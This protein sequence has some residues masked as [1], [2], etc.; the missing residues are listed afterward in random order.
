M[1]DR[2]S[3]QRIATL[4]AQMQALAEDVA[5]QV[6]GHKGPVEWGD[7]DGWLLGDVEKVR[8]DG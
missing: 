5:E 8:D 1:A 3:E 7:E 4:E 6:Y 2:T